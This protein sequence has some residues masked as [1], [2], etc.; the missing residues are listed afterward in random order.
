MCGAGAAC[1]RSSKQTTVALSSVEAEFYACSEGARETKWAKGL[2]EE[3]TKFKNGPVPLFMDSQGAMALANNN[4]VTRRTKHIDIKHFFIRDLIDDKVI[5]TIYVGTESNV[6]DILTKSLDFVK[7]EK[8]RDGLGIISRKHA[9]FF[10]GV[11]QN[12]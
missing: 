12:K 2:Y 1:W 11:C 7:F 4:S 8:H 6:A 5:K 9:S 3:L 10:E